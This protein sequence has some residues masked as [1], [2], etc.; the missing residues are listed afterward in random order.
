M[1]LL[2]TLTYNCTL[3]THI[4]YQFLDHGGLGLDNSLRSWDRI[5]RPD[6]VFRVNAI[7]SANVYATLK[8]RKDGK[9]FW[10]ESSWTS[11]HLSDEKAEIVSLLVLS[12]PYTTIGQTISAEATVKGLRQEWWIETGVLGGNPLWQE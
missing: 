10:W 1:K 5:R 12:N 2:K 11:L 4:T 8:G 7:G 6:L 3:W 9:Y